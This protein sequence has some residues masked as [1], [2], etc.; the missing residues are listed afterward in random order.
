[1]VPLPCSSRLPRSAGHLREGLG[2]CLTTT[3]RPPFRSRAKAVTPRSI[4]AGSQR[5]GLPTRGAIAAQ[6][7]GQGRTI[8]RSTD[9]S[10]GGRAAPSR[11]VARGLSLSPVAHHGARLIASR[12]NSVWLLERVP[13]PEGRRGRDCYSTKI[14]EPEPGDELGAY[15]PEQLVA[16]DQKFIARMLDVVASGDERLPGAERLYVERKQT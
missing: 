12:P 5:G 11:P 4:S 1:M 2:D 9:R 13:T 3:I 8:G 10:P 6:A 15:S 14:I 16:M 7:P